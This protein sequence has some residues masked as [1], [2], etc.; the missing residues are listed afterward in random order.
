[1]QQYFNLF[2]MYANL[3]KQ[4]THTFTDDTN[5][6]ILINDPV[7]QVTAGESSFFSLK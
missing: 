1:M 5:K 6:L 3:G 2:V 7:T 4:I